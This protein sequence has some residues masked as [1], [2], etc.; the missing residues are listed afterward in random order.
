M[1]KKIG[2]G[3]GTICFVI[4]GLAFFI[5]AAKLNN[6]DIIGILTSSQAFLIYGIAIFVIVCVFSVCLINKIGRK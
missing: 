3:I 4:I 5:I 6:W 2:I 1:N